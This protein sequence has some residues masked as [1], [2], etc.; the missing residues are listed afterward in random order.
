MD[1]VT[2]VALLILVHK[3]CEQSLSHVNTLLRYVI[4]VTFFKV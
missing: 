2:S 1:F 4:H 3:S